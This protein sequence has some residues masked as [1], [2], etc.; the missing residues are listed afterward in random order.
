[1]SAP[2]IDA[3]PGVNGTPRLQP[4]DTKIEACNP[5]GDALRI[6]ATLL[7][8]GAPLR[9]QVEHGGNVAE[10]SVRRGG[11]VT[12]ELPIATTTAVEL[13]DLQNRILD[14]LRQAS[15]SSEISSAWRSLR[16]GGSLSAAGHKRRPH[17]SE[18]HLTGKGDESTIIRRFISFD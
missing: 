11:Q 15:A 6:L 4:H 7:T 14:V 18:K 5:L 9:V 8:T 1:M 17:S 3:A 12:T 2:Q 13:T 16:L 10:L